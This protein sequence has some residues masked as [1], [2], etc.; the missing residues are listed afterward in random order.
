MVEDVAVELFELFDG[1]GIMTNAY[2]S[3]T[4]LRMSC[5]SAPD[6]TATVGT[7]NPLDNDESEFDSSSVGSR[8]ESWW[9]H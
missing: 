3:K 8:F 2:D 6:S 7:S 9:V 1:F 5:E 4:S